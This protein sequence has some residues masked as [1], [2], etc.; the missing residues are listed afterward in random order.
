MVAP[1]I[2]SVVLASPQTNMKKSPFKQLTAILN[3][4]GSSSLQGKAAMVVRIHLQ[5][6]GEAWRQTDAQRHEA[7][8]QKGGCV[9]K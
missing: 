3:G 5:H 4:V 1:E 6:Q 7:N 2:V 8:R 9:A